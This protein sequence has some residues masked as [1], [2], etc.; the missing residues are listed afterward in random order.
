M[1]VTYYKRYRMEIDLG[2][3]SLPAES[4][5]AS[6]EWV[7]WSP[8]LLERHALAKFE[9]F[10]AEIDSEVFPTL[11][12]PASCRCLMSEIVQRATFVPDATWLISCRLAE[13]IYEDCGTIQGLVQSGQWGAIQNVGVAVEHR[14]KGLGKALVLKSLRGFQQ[15]GVDRVYLEVTARNAVAVNLYRSLGF[16]LARTTY[17]AVEKPT[18]IYAV[19]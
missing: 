18:P 7:A 8:N 12:D 5:P 16:C 15:A 10:R 2:R 13:G 4:L 11:G 6:Y 17:K 9:S 14:G 1:G 3:V 19:L